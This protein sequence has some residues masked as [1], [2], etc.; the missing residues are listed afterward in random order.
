MKKINL[1]PNKSLGD[2]TL[3]ESVNKYLHLPH[4]VKNH[5]DYVSYNFDLLGVTLWLNNENNIDTIRCTRQCY[6]NGA[7]LIN[8]PID[9]FLSI[10]SLT[11]DDIEDIYVLVSEN[12]GQN[13]TA[14]TFSDLGIM[15]WT[16]RNKIKTVLV[17]NY[18]I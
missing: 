17:S 18:N 2:F 15:V 3:G 4:E 12:R 11:P 10:Y 1:L 9:D 16:W 8:M 5:G 13:Q 6:W 14:Y 7:N